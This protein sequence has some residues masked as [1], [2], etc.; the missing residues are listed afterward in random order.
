M[1]KLFLLS[2]S[3]C[4]VALF[5]MAQSKL[6][7][8]MRLKLLEQSE[9][10]IQK[11]NS[12]ESQK[13]EAFIHFN[14]DVDLALLERYNVE[15]HSVFHDLG[16]VTAY[17]DLSS[18]EALA[19][20][21]SIKEIEASTP[22]YT[23][24]DQARKIA[25]VDEI[26]RG[27]GSLNNVQY[28]GKDVVVGVYDVGFQ[29]T[30]AAFRDPE[31]TANTRIKRVWEQSTKSS[32]YPV[33]SG[34]NYGFELSTQSQ[35][36]E[37]QYDARLT[38]AIGHGSHVAGIAVGGDMDRIYYG[39]APQADIVLVSADMTSN[40]SV[41]DAIK[42]IFE[43]ATSVGKPAVVNLSMG[44]H[45]GPHDGTSTLD[46][47]MDNLQGPGRIIV[48]SVGNEGED[49][50]HASKSF[51]EQD[52]ILKTTIKFL[53]LSYKYS[54]IDIWGDVDK[55]FEYQVVLVQKTN[56]SL[57]YASPFY[58]AS[59]DTSMSINP[60]AY[61]SVVADSIIAD[62]RVGIVAQKNANNNKYNVTVK[63]YVTKM[64]NYGY[65]IGVVIKAKEG[66]V[67][68]WADDYLSGLSNNNITGWDDGD[69]VSSMGEIGGTGNRIISVGAL[70]SR[71]YNS[72]NPYNHLA[73]F[74]SKGPT[75]DGRVKP[76]I[77]APGCYLISAIPNTNRVV[78]SSTFDE[79]LNFT[80]N[81][82]TQYYAYMQ[83]TSMSS[84]FAAGVI[85]TWLQAD[86]TLTPERLREVFAKTSIRDEFTD[87]ICPNNDFGYGKINAN[88][89][90]LYVLGKTT[91]NDIVDAESANSIIVYPNPSA[92]E[93]NVG[94][95]GA[96]SN[97]NIS[98]Y[99]VDGK[100]VYSQSIGNVLPGDSEI[101]NLSNVNNGVYIVRVQG[102]NT[103]Q[104][105]RLLI[106]K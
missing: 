41:S 90:L 96:D 8:S 40:A 63:T 7:N 18:V 79:A 100:L 4:F 34:F 103:L 76:D 19:A 80:F 98:I 35:I 94:F 78:K 81:G 99:S 52:S 6:S 1:K 58:K 50:F 42:Y 71:A 12:Q 57:L 65:Y 48:G 39:A 11:A 45:S 59:V 85:A 27:D 13:V 60:V 68:M 15:V 91:A 55:D 2:F 29:Y 93:V 77:T 74:S 89:G 33:P 46:R 72:S 64:P 106:S 51:S 53:D 82:E 56:N 28:K 92:G 95:L 86:P 88:A 101:I 69:A 9:T 49:K 36:F 3:L 104:S 31:N 25:H 67:H 22:M 32:K 83:G 20:E 17:I 61:H 87:N 102:E 30:H 38:D 66:T 5:S 73:G 44:S 47:L 26:H 37:R 16:I 21:S 23:R 97:I 43:Y 24:L 10:S 54:T 70:V 84:P 75:P 105:H 14:G 62:A